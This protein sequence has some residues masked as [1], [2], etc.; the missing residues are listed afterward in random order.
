VVYTVNME[1]QGSP[2]QGVA[3]VLCPHPEAGGT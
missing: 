1:P 2:G 3:G